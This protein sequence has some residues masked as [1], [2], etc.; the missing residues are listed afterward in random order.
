M[1]ELS[2]YL[3]GEL[4]PGERSAV[5]AHLAECPACS[6]EL[7]LLGEV[8]SRVDALPRLSAPAALAGAVAR[9]LREA[10][11]AAPRVGWVRRLWPAAAAACIGFILI[12][13]TGE[14]PDA[15]PRSPSEAPRTFAKDA[16][17]ASTDRE[18]P[19]VYALKSAPP[20]KGMKATAPT[21][22]SA[23]LAAAKPSG[24]VEAAKRDRLAA[25]RS[26][27]ALAPPVAAPSMT[28]MRRV[29][30][31]EEVTAPAK[32]TQAPLRVRRLIVRD[33]DPDAARADLAELLREMKVDPPNTRQGR[34]HF[35]CSAKQYARLVS[36]LRRRGRRV[37]ER[38]RAPWAVHSGPLRRATVVRRVATAKAERLP[39]A[40]LADRA[41]AS[42]LRRRARLRVAPPGEG[43]A[44]GGAG[45]GAGRGAVFEARAGGAA[46][47]AQPAPK[48]S[49]RLG[50][51]RVETEVAKTEHAAAKLSRDLAVAKVEMGAARPKLAAARAKKGAPRYRVT[52]YF[53][54]APKRPVAPKAPAQPQ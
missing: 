14:T 49:K 48:L 6:E 29:R 27:E 43:K 53:L 23:P 10:P 41:P 2:A 44:F 7:R 9:G 18:A 30:R 35:V 22:E 32:P 15:M 20:A 25:T 34:V 38:G 51:A 3:D 46:P 52:V 21:L 12:V 1:E 40:A 24:G 37:S 8:V 36:A 47:K 17:A 45:G 13:M 16:K 50:V 42:G 4:T 39:R 28:A 31:A 54:P 19:R 26:R 33:V 5:E 11:P